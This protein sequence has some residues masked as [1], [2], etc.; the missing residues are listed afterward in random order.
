MTVREL[1]AMGAGGDFRA[2]LGVAT[3]DEGAGEA[4]RRAAVLGRRAGKL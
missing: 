3:G 1:G 4:R 2:A